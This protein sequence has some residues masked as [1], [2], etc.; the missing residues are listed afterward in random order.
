[1]LLL[2]QFVVLC[3]LLVISTALRV[4][5]IQLGDVVFFYRIVYLDAAPLPLRTLRAVVSGRAGAGM[6]CFTP[7]GH[8]YVEELTRQAG[9][10]VS[11]VVDRRRSRPLDEAVVMAVVAALQPSRVGDVRIRTHTHCVLS[12]S[13]LMECV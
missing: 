4:F 12:C 9:A 11:G 10:V 6:V 7:P 3:T 2:D 8:R 5:F 1:M 13:Q